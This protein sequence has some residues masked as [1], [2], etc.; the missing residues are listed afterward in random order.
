L[1]YA[2]GSE[3]AS[4]VTY[5]RFQC[6][7]SGAALA[8][9]SGHLT[10][11]L[12]AYNTADSILPRLIWFGQSVASRQQLL[13]S[14]PANLTPGAAACAISLG[15]LERAVEL[16]DHGRS[17]F[18]SQAMNIRTSLS[19]LKNF[20]APLAREFE[21]VALALDAGAFQDQESD[22]FT[23]PG[24]G[25][26]ASNIEHRRHLADQLERLLLRIRA[27]PDFEN[28]MEPLPFSQLCHAALDGPVIILNVSS[29]RCDALIVTVGRPPELVPLPHM[30]LDRASE[31]AAS[32]RKH[33]NGQSENPR[34]FRSCLKAVLPEIWQTTVLPVLQALGLTDPQDQ[35]R[36]KPRIWWYPTGPLSFLPIHAA[37]PYNQTGGPSLLYR[38]VS[39]YTSTL[40]ALLRARSQDRP[41]ESCRMLL[42][43]QAETP[44]Q[45]PLPSATKDLDAVSERARSHGITD[46]TRLEGADGVQASILEKL[47]NATCAHFACHGHQ[48]QTQNGLIS[49]LRVHDGPL[50]LSTIASR[51]LPQADFAFLSAC[52]SASGSE[53][54][55]D[56]A[57][58]IAAGMQVAGFRS[59]VATMW[60]M[61]DRTGPF[62]AEKVYDRLLRNASDKFDSTEAAV[63]L[64][65]AVRALRKVKD[66]KGK[67]EYEVDQWVPFVHIGV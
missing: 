17:I 59:V 27:L 56:E 31:L 61:D 3:V 13:R 2:D 1:E 18:W 21:S 6:A 20:D 58:H 11:A 35:S 4:G 15:F 7:V 46:V 55:P 24:S 52:H 44:G 22:F 5:F 14:K 66:K 12:R 37:G 33:Q 45:K 30:T 67:P 50:L 47:S 40:S 62:V 32:V 64:N 65:H 51:Q 8:H 9:T 29:Y 53:D 25:S 43:G 28:F 54:M 41:T 57:M 26:I 39:S 60:A 10:Q 63:S 19:D 34:G 36:P 48:D 49:A 23:L 42:I 16:L 38:I